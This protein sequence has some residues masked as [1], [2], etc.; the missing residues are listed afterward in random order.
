VYCL[1]VVVGV[2]G[3]YNGL[4]LWPCGHA[5]LYPVAAA[6]ILCRGG[7]P[8]MVLVCQEDVWL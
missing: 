6:G 2:A 4:L 3:C 8:F 5:K 7:V 1:L